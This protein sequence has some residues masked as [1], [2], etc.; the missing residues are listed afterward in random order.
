MV[1]ASVCI[2]IRMPVQSEVMKKQNLPG[3]AFVQAHML[4]LESRKYFSRAFCIS[5]SIDFWKTRHE[6]HIREIQECLHTN[7]TGNEL[8]E[9]LKTANATELAPCHDVWWVPSIEGPNAT[10][11]FMTQTPEEIH[12]AGK[13]PPMDAMF[14]I[15]S[16]VLFVKCSCLAA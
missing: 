13:T 9:Y 8:V 11:P 14:S 3:G 1:Q 15:V 7:K 5:G 4:N 12:K 10:R 16:Q 2:P 6:N